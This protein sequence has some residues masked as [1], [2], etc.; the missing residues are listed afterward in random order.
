MCLLTFMQEY[1][2]A[3]TDEL[4]IGSVNNPDGF[5]Y[6][7]HAGTHIV[8]GSGLNFDAVL[9]TSLRHEQFILVLLCF[10]PE[11]PHMVVPILTT[12]T[13]FKLVRTLTRL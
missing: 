3:D 11:S 5:G 6:A 4:A 10:T 2:T 12:V 1:T 13:R 9:I 7:V 8:K